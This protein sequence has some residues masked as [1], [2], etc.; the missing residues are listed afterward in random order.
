MSHPPLYDN[1]LQAIG[2]TPMV[3]FNRIGKEYPVEIFGKCEFLSPGGSLK[4]R[5]GLAMIEKA[6]REGRIKPGDTLVE[7]TSGNT[8][9]GLALAA[10]IKGYRLII[11]MPMKMSMEKQATM[12]ALGAE[13]IRT[14]T[15][16]KSTDPESNFGVAKRLVEEMPNAHMLDQFKNSANPDI[17]YHATAGEILE[18]MGR[19]ID[20]LVIGIGT[21]GALSG[22]AQRFRDENIGCKVVAVDP[23]GS[24]MGGGTETSS[25]LV[26]GIGYDFLPDVFDP[27]LMD[28]VVKTR[29]KESFD[30]ALRVIREEGLLVGGSSGSTVWAAL[31]IAKKCKGGERIVVILADSVRN[32]MTKFLQKDWMREKGFID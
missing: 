10:A 7:P 13:I 29:D 5:I 24:V 18:Q 26:E 23:V 17:H 3:R 4:D 27:K 2:N 1:I 11:C 15:E 21:G 30:M 6:E 25:Y 22:I 12:E 16:A 32:Y 9:I 31:E 14:P 19:K 28:E 20:Y 8:G